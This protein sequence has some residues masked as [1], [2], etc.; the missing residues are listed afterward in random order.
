M[1]I[2]TGSPR[3]IKGHAISGALMGLMMSGVREYSKYKQGAISK[4]RFLQVALKSG[5]E[6]GII[7]SSGIADANALGNTTKKPSQNILE[8]VVVKPT[9]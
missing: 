3:S 9:Q 1:I 7:A 4:D 2:N 5:L 6:G 8:A